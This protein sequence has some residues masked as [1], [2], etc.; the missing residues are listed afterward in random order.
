MESSSKSVNARGSTDGKH[1]D[2]PSPPRWCSGVKCGRLPGKSTRTRTS[3]RR[4]DGRYSES[5]GDRGVLRCRTWSNSSGAAKMAR[6][7]HTRKPPRDMGFGVAFGGWLDQNQL[8]LRP[9]G[10]DLRTRFVHEHVDLAAHAEPARQVDPG[11]DREP[12]PGHERALVGGLEV[13]DVRAGAVQVTVDRVARAVHEVLG[14]AGGPDDGARGIVH[15]APGGDPS[16]FPLPRPLRTVSEQGHRGITR[17][18]HRL[19][20]LADLRVRRPSS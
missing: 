10:G 19:P 7:R 13:V 2:T 1:D 17:P 9:P 12:D 6:I 4:S 15:L 18:P 8:L 5:D 14:V 16:P 20:N 11:L 3:A